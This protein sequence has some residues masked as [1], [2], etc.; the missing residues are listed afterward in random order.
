MTGAMSRGRQLST[1]DFDPFSIGQ[2]EVDSA[3]SSDQECLDR[4][5]A[6]GC[7]AIESASFEGGI[8]SITG[9]SLMLHFGRHTH[10]P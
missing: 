7:E 9:A 10:T 1:K 4:Y 2:P 3:L 8:T 5:I 6:E